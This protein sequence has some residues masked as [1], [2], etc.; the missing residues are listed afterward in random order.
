MHR[1]FQIRAHQ[2]HVPLEVLVHILQH[3]L[4]ETITDVQVDLVGL[5]FGFWL[6]KMLKLVYANTDLHT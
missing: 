3:W 4:M 5:Y 6:S 2:I 1:L